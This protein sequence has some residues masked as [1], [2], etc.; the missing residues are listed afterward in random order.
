MENKR[1]KDEGLRDFLEAVRFWLTLFPHIGVCEECG[2][3][4]WVIGSSEGA[5]LF[6]SDECAAEAFALD[7]D[8]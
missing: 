1:A 2:R 8:F 5:P 7:G 3:K 6:C 4:F